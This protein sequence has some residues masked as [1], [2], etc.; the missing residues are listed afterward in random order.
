M[1]E[2]AVIT[3]QHVS[4]G[5]SRSSVLEDVNLTVHERDF[6][7][8]VGPNG[9]GKTTL[10]K[11]MLGLLQPVK[12]NVQVLGGSPQEARSRIGYM[13]QYVD[14]DPH[15]PVSVKDIV[16]MGRL[17]NGHGFG[18]YTHEDK[19]AAARALAGVGLNDLGER[20][21]STLS[22][23]Q[24]RRLLIARALA[25]EPEILMLDE[26]MANLDLVVAE[27]I[28]GLLHHLNQKLTVVM[29]SHDPA[30]V[31]K[32]VK[33]VVCVNKTVAIHPTCE[34]DSR[35]LGDLYRG[36]MRMVRHDQHAEGEQTE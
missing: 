19:E 7:W 26:P 25:S 1:S 14:I 35:M 24:Q 15:F 13:P 5:Y 23:G 4:F 20:H 22:G 3:I 28:Q 29:V 9:G 10:L 6:I 2:R 12:G 34:V 11:L 8:V 33:N 30:L 36:Q 27:D 18:R 16:L 31:S 17:G 32:N 21:F